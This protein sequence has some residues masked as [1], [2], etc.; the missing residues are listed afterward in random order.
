MRPPASR[1]ERPR[2]SVASTGLGGERMDFGLLLLRLAVG[3]TFAAHGS[4]KL[5]GW[6]GGYGIEGTGQFFEQ[7]GFVPGRRRAFMAGLAEAGGGLLLASGAATPLA[8]AVLVAVMLVAI[9]SV[10]VPK[11]FFVTNGG[12]EHP[13]VLAL[14]ASSLGFAGP[15]RFSVDA[16]LGLDFAGSSWGAAALAVGLAGG[17][18]QLAGRRRASAQPHK[19]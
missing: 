6:F 17:V 16:L 1:S 13:L 14:A 15:G 7:L 3:L 9:V 8:A 19:A 18:L 12:Y 11:G 4:Q 5:F 2:P 10:H